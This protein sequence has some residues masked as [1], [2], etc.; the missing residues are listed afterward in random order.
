MTQHDISRKMGLPLPDK[1]CFH[2]RDST[3]QIHMTFSS[4]GIKR[5]LFLS[6]LTPFLHAT[7]SYKMTS[8]GQTE[9]Q[10]MGTMR[11]MQCSLLSK[12]SVLEA[13]KEVLKLDDLRN[14]AFWSRSVTDVGTRMGVCKEPTWRKLITVLQWVINMLRRK[15]LHHPPS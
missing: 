5:L 13:L 1:I 11:K 14:R 6:L 12:R 7:N 3:L 4:G 9:Y 2:Y 10:T 8:T 15:E